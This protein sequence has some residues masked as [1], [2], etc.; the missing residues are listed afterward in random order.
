MSNFQVNRETPHFDFGQHRKE[1]QGLLG[2]YGSAIAGQTPVQTLYGQQ[3]DRFGIPQLAETAQRYGEMASRLGD[4]IRALP[5]QMGERTR[6]SLVT[7]G[8]RQR[9]IQSEAAPMMESAAQFGSL[10]EQAGQRLSQ[11]QQMAGTMTGLE[12]QQQ[13]REL[14]PFEREFSMQD[15]MQ[16]RE[17]TGYTFR[18]TQELNRLLQNAQLGFQWSNAEKQ[19]AHELSLKELDYREALKQIAATGEQ[20][21]RVAAVQGIFR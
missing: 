2:R 11:A 16:A 20:Q 1:A 12:M 15:Q 4:S 21:A 17:L 6:E 8:Q 14:L 7:E 3:M 18:E 13:D 10:A 9:M 19:R 5:K